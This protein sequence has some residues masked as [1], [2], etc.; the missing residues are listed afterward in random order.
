MLN[1]L[2]SG[3]VED[4]VI[5]T[6]DR[7]KRDSRPSQHATLRRAVELLALG[8]FDGAAQAAHAVLREDPGHVGALETL[9]KAL[10]KEGRYPQV[11][12]VIARLVR[13]NPYEPGYHTLRGAAL[14]CLG[15]YGEAMRAYRRASSMKDAGLALQDLQTWQGELVAE[16]IQS[17]P[18]FRAHYAQNPVEACESRGFAFGA[19]AE[20]ESHQLSPAALRAVVSVRPS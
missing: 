3:T 6:N 18:V 17:D 15:R 12:P 16:L 9:V 1:N 4:A 20:E 10:W 5:R 2:R 8:D 14:Q 13:L 19:S 11:L 7:K